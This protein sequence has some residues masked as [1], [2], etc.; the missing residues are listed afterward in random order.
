MYFQI[1]FIYI[2]IIIFQFSGFNLAEAVNFAPPDWLEMGRKCVENYSYMR[3]YCVFC[4]DEI[5]CKMATQV[6]KLTLQVRVL[7]N[8]FVIVCLP[9]PTTNSGTIL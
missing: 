3:R 1:F 9:D 7:L 4:H 2:E 8:Y 6:H 5:V